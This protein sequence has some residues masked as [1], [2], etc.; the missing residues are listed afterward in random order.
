MTADEQIDTNSCVCTIIHVQMFTYMTEFTLICKSVFCQGTGVNPEELSWWLEE[1]KSG[2]AQRLT[3]A[4]FE[5]L[6][7]ASTGATT[8]DWFVML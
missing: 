7:Q 2:S 5:H 4:D 8:G 6:T 3:D 1:N